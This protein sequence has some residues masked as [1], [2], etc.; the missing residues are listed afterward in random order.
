[1]LLYLVT[2]VI[3][4]PLNGRIRTDQLSYTWFVNSVLMRKYKD[5]LKGCIQN[6][7]WS[8]KSFTLIIFP[9]QEKLKLNFAFGFLFIWC[10][11]SLSPRLEKEFS[12]KKIDRRH[13]NNIKDKAKLWHYVYLRPNEK[14]FVVLNRKA[15]A[16]I[17]LCEVNHTMFQPTLYRLV[18]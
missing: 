8:E 7:T 5:F 15:I 12:Q 17:R 3:R 11:T 16:K 9:K 6:F 10:F 4:E 18:C 13:H 14:V 2:H 1:M